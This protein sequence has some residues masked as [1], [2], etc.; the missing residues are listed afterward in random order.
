MYFSGKYVHTL[1]DNTDAIPVPVDIESPSIPLKKKSEPKEEEPSSS[2]FE[3]LKQICFQKDFIIFVTVNFMQIFQYTYIGNF[4][5]IFGDELL[6]EHVI[7]PLLRKCLYG[8]A[9]MLPQ[10]SIDI[11]LNIEYGNIFLEIFWC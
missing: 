4:L 6:P 2:F 5:S 11:F 1:Y 7:S 3:E 10:V 9:F 8:S